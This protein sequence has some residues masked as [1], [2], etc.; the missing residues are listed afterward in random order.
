MS[1]QFFHLLLPE[2]VI[3]SLFFHHLLLAAYVDHPSLT[4]DDNKVRV[5][6][7]EGQVVTIPLACLFSC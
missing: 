6:N 7:E 1:R 3:D 2:L 4:Q 5:G